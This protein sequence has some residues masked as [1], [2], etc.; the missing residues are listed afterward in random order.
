[1]VNK[2]G[3]TVFVFH[4]T[5]CVFTENHSSGTVM[6]LSGEIGIDSKSVVSEIVC[7]IHMM[8]QVKI[9]KRSIFTMTNTKIKRERRRRS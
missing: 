5:F 9:Q 3:E 7:M 6:T 8:I 2:S 1:M 4:Y